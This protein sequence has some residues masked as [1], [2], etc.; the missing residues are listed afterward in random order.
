[1]SSALQ[2]VTGSG[3]GTCHHAGIPCLPSLSLRRIRLVHLL[4]E[5]LLNTR[6]CAL[7]AGK[8]TGCLIFIGE[9]IVL[10][11]RIPI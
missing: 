4:D 8:M 3:T 7:V 11:V 6:H 10:I 5:Y 2:K 1:M 9:L